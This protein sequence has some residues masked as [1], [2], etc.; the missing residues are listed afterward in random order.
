MSKLIYAMSVSADGFVA[1]RDGDIGWGGPTDELFRFHTDRVRRLGGYLLGRRLYEMLTYWE[2]ADRDPALG[3]NRREFA[4]IWQ[5]LPKVVF[6]T[7]LEGVG[8]NARLARGGVV[9]EAR[10][11]REQADGDLEIG[12]PTLA[13]TCIEHDLV[14]EYRLF[15]YPV[16]LGGGTPYLPSTSASLDLE[17]VE[18]R[19]FA[20][21]IV[22]LRYRRPR[23]E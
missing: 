21:R 17:L 18:T 13:A 6:S 23:P 8:G 1:D 4:G 20:S 10:R 14:D 9:E 16:I 7:T 5:R 3:A 12:G 2:T 19:S 15:V 22:Y 11:L